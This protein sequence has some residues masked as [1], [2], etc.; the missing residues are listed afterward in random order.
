MVN[1]MDIPRYSSIKR[2]ML[3][4][5]A[6]FLIFMT[7]W[8]SS[9]VSSNYSFS[10]EQ[11]PFSAAKERLS[12]SDH[13]K[14]SQISVYKD[15]IVIDIDNAVWARYT[16]SNSMDPLF[17]KGANGLEL[18][19]SSTED[20]K[21]GDI[22]AYQASWTEGTVIHRIIEIG[23]DEKGI[24]YITKGD[25]NPSQDPEKVRFSQVKYIL[26]GILY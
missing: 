20:L 23:N 14:E 18:P 21:I 25:N 22:I 19:V 26:I 13:I 10:L 12:P 6:I 11:L 4:I 16:D 3:T 8:F 7:G 9:L 17:D 5:A 24:Y 15:R 1:M 2:K